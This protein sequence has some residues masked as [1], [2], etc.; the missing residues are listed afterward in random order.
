MWKTASPDRDE[1]LKKYA[2]ENRQHQ[3]EAER[4][5]WEIVRAERLGYKFTRQHIIG[6]F[7]ADFYASKLD[8]VVEID[9]GYHAERQQQEDDKLRTQWFESIGIRVIRFTNEEVIWNYEQVSS[10]LLEFIRQT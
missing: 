8:I 10:R 9:G 1:L 4:V 2:L 3:T 5:F 6:D 7:I